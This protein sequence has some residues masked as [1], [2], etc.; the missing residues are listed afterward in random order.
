MGR[1][2]QGAEK[3]GQEPPES[4]F[5]PCNPDHC[6]GGPGANSVWG[7][8]LQAGVKSWTWTRDPPTALSSKNQRAAGDI[9]DRRRG[10][11]L[12]QEPGQ[13]WLFLP[14]ALLNNFSWSLLCPHLCLLEEVTWQSINST[15]VHS[16]CHSQMLLWGAC[17]CVRFTFYSES[18][19]LL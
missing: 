8:Q 13:S 6:Y 11:A 2:G 3:R 7:Q 15:S 12:L 19:P 14:T 9:S 4:T 16:S 1:R 5:L 10:A 17:N 18:T